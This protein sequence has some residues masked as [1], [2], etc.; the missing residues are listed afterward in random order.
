M[1]TSLDAAR[2]QYPAAYFVSDEDLAHL[3]TLS[4]PSELE[5]KN[6]FSKLFTAVVGV[7]TDAQQNILA[8]VDSVGN[9]VEF[10]T[11]IASKGKAVLGW[12]SELRAAIPAQLRSLLLE[13]WASH[14]EAS[15]PA[16]AS[17]YPAQVGI[18]ILQ[19][20]YTI[21]INKA[22][23][24]SSLSP[25]E[26]SL[27][28]QVAES[29]K[30]VAATLSA[31]EQ[32]NLSTLMTVAISQADQARRLAKILADDSL[33]SARNAWSQFLQ[34]TLDSAS[35]QVTVRL[36]DTSVPYGFRF[37][38]A[39]RL[40]RF[41]VTDSIYHATLAGKTAVV[42]RG[43]AGTGKTET[44]KDLAADLGY[45]FVVINSS[46]AMG[47]AVIEVLGRA[48]E[49]NPDTV[50]IF[51]EFNRLFAGQPAAAAALLQRATDARRA[52]RIPL[53]AAFTYNPSSGTPVPTGDAAVVDTTAPDLMAVTRV[54]FATEGVAEYAA[55][56][57]LTWGFLD[58]AKGSL[59]TQP[60][61]DWGLRTIKATARAA[62]RLIAL[63][64]AAGAHDSVRR[65]LDG[66]VVARLT[67]EDRAAAEAQLV[68]VFGGPAPAPLAVSVG[69]ATSAVPGEQLG[70]VTRPR[71]AAPAGERDSRLRLC[72]S[73]CPRPPAN[74]C[75]SVQKTGKTKM[76]ERRVFAR[77]ACFLP[78]LRR[79]P[80]RG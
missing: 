31:R 16:L 39:D 34:Y 61:Y 17:K 11:P 63:G 15:L 51:D 35:G 42:I 53:W 7:R 57:E 58:W 20:R 23:E 66:T 29:A 12:L 65:A 10:T 79:P 60:V 75:Q 21:S 13:A 18:L 45:D 6:L 59:S 49:A 14:S 19:L 22:L 78:G 71:A 40:V 64:A 52:G 77:A 70:Q 36:G 68:K 43:A 47:P 56:A 4:S 46:D 38:P 30:A 33:V 73:P 80:G 28:A 76:R 2:T 74:P 69:A 27:A 50:V 54:T 37:G 9:A 55:A 25:V 48:V 72:G 26:E 62:G 67:A 5:A 32:K 41:A 1:S 44:Q 24:S 3:L 8:V